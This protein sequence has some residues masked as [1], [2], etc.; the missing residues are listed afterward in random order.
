MP[1]HAAV[2]LLLVVALPGCRP[3]A[4][5]RATLERRWVPGVYRCEGRD[6]LEVSADRRAGADVATRRTRITL[7]E[8]AELT[9]REPDASGLKRLEWRPR[10]L[11]MARDGGARCDSDAD[12][13]TPAC[14]APRA[15]TRTVYGGHVNPDGTATIT[16]IAAGDDG[17]AERMWAAFQSW[18]N[19]EAELQIAM[20]DLRR[21]VSVN[22]GP[23]DRTPRAVSAGDTWS[24]TSTVSA[25]TFPGAAVELEFRNE[26][27]RI[28]RTPG[29]E[30]VTIVSTSTRGFPGRE[31]ALGRFDGRMARAD[32]R[33]TSVF[34]VSLGMVT[35]TRRALSG[36]SSVDFGP[37]VTGTI[38]Y[39]SESS[40]TCR[41]AGE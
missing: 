5:R 13:A 14:F 27:E 41:R 6:W 7:D 31:V 17:A 23:L 29:G 30:T 34:D 24:S 22:F 8:L 21:V 15:M 16:G 3:D 12:A 4:P 36:A 38:E 20:G 19:A 10:H 18:M 33:S 32:F 35:S 9:V 26:V 37:G 39:R 2:A 11:V 25:P 28:E 1:L 40:T